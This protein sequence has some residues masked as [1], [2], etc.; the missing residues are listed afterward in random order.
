MI[1]PAFLILVIM[2][3]FI[4]LAISYTQRLSFGVLI[5]LR[6]STR[7]V[8]LQHTMTCLRLYLREFSQVLIF[9]N[10]QNLST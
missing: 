4:T 3:L 1:M 2:F 7:Q 6:K 5:T 9:P 8:R 10:R